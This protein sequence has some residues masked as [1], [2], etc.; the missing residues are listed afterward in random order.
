MAETAPAESSAP[1]SG[2]RGGFGGRGRGRGGGRGRGRGGP[3]GKYS[4]TCFGL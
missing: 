3:R 2:F 1:P 4:C